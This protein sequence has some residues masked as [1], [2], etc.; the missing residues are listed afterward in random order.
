MAAPAQATDAQEITD[1]LFAELGEAANV[2]LLNDA[3]FEG[4]RLAQAEMDADMEDFERS[5]AEREVEMAHAREELAHAREEM[6]EAAREM[7]RLGQEMAG[8]VVIRM[9]D[10]QNKAMLGITLESSDETGADGVGVAGVSSDGPAANAGL[11]AG[12]VLVEIDGNSLKG[13][14]DESAIVK[15]VEYMKDVEPGQK[16][17]VDYLRDGKPYSV[18]IETT[19]FAFPNFA[20]DFNFG[21][22]LENLENELR[23]LGEGDFEHFE[24]VVP[25]GAFA[26]HMPRGPNR[27]FAFGGH[28]LHGALGDME[29]VSLTPEL[30]DYFGTKKGLLVVRAPKNEDIDIRDGDVILKIGDREPSSPGQVFRIIGSYEA[31]DTVELQVMR[32]KKKRNLKITLPEQDDKVRIWKDT[33][34]DEVIIHELRTQKSTG[35]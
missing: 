35:T 22:G 32:K 28:R 24:F 15:L 17:N 14:D 12:D 6:E 20:F 31:G 13:D 11:Q 27:R 3:A 18:V 4:M 5:R 16:V 25:D 34:G 8:Q 21:E 26:P 30:G 1:E 23:V 29:M 9:R 7:A 33:D 2:E 10:R 19:E